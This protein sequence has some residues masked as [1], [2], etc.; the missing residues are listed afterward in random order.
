MTLLM[1]AAWRGDIPMFTFL[2]KECGADKDK[3]SSMGR[4]VADYV[5]MDCAGKTAYDKTLM[6]KL[7]YVDFLTK[8][9]AG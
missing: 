4:K 9:N 6:S 7:L 5:K 1:D 3:R 8:S 2:I